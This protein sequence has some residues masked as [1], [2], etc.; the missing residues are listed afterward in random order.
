MLTLKPYSIWANYDDVMVASWWRHDAVIALVANVQRVVV[1]IKQ[2]LY[3]EVDLNFPVQRV[4]GPIVPNL[5]EIGI[6]ELCLADIAEKT[7][8]LVLVFERWQSQLVERFSA[9]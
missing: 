2:G 3:I 7:H 6:M 5:G 4:L 9:F 8:F 1:W